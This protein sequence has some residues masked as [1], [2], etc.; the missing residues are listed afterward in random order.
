MTNRLVNGKTLQEH[1]QHERK[2]IRMDESSMDRKPTLIKKSEMKAT[3]GNSP[4][5]V[6][7]MIMLEYLYLKKINSYV[8]FNF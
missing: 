5:F 3:I 1:L 7:A 2:A 8:E 4:D 6:E